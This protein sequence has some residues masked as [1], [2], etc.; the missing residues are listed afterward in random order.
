MGKLVAS[1]V[2]IDPATAAKWLLS[3][4]RNRPLSEPYVT[5]LAAEMAE[6]RWR[7]NG[8]TIV[9]DADG[10]LLDGQHR[11]EAVRR[12]GVAVESLV[13]RGV[14]GDVFAT[15]GRGRIRTIADALSLAGYKNTILLGSVLGWIARYHAGQT[16]SKAWSHPSPDASVQ[17]AAEHP[18]TGESLSLFT[19][20]GGRKRYAGALA[21]VAHYLFSKVDREAAEKFAEDLL[22]GV[23]LAGDD[24]VYL[25]RER[26]TGKDSSR[27]GAH[28]VTPQTVTWQYYVKAWN[29][30]RRDVR[31]QNLTW[32]TSEGQIEIDGYPSAGKAKP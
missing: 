22:T 19:R 2:V 29:A 30:R 26:L 17:L 5:K 20:Y 21:V 1:V 31:T 6:G 23:G 14:S 12:S 15:L 13:A 3:N 16:A 27:R 18:E 4:T 28:G 9:F 10:V 25:L 7:T 24:P 11:L 32:R 8:E